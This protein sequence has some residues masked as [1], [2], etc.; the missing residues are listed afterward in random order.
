MTAYR[1]NLIN[2]MI[3]LYGYEDPTVISFITY[4]EKW[5]NTMRNNTDL[6]NIVEAHEKRIKIELD[7]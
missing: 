2:R 7:K 6:E 1:E 4:C 3:N 5:A